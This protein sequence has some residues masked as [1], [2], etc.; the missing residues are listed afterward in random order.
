[1]AVLDAMNAFE[2]PV[3]PIALISPSIALHDGARLD[4]KPL[5][6]NGECNIC[7]SSST[8]RGLKLWGYTRP[9]RETCNLQLHLAMNKLRR[10][11]IVPKNPLDLRVAGSSTQKLKT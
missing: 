2:Q 7:R 8:T 11:R 10:T 9:K 6:A 5:L 1:M 3:G 4:H